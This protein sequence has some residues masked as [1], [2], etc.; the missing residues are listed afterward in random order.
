MR[1]TAKVKTKILSASA[2]DEALNQA[3]WS[4][5]HQ[6]YNISFDAF[7]ERWSRLDEV[8]LFYRQHQA[9]QSADNTA[10]LVGCIG[11]R[12]YDFTAV[13]KERITTLYF[14][15]VYIQPA[16][17]G[18]M[19]VQR[20]VIRY[21]LSIKLRHPWR[22]AFFW[23]DALSYKPYLVMANNLKDYWPSPHRL[24]PAL[25]SELIRMIGERY[26]GEDFDPQTGTVRKA[27]NI[28]NDQSVVIT[29][30]D[31]TNPYIAYYARHN[32]EHANGH[33]LI[34]VC[35]LNVKNVLWFM[36]KPLRKIKRR[37]FSHAYP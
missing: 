14:G 36:L 27:T 23:T 28:L 33:G 7:T 25:I 4:L 30:K 6:A 12:F 11:V 16:Y 13:N 26:Y 31:L 24:T 15:Q 22:P 5:Y 35:K 20:T 2:I 3:I 37:Y 8:V 19:L 34:L 32:P 10:E 1:L 18:R 9:G 29:E 21:M 17:R